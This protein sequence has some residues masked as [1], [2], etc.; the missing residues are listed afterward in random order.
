MEKPESAVFKQP[1]GQD[2]ECEEQDEDEQVCAVLSVTL[3]S[4]FLC[5]DVLHSTVLLWWCCSAYTDA[6]RQAHQRQQPQRPRCPPGTAD[7]HFM[8]H[9]GRLAS[10]EIRRL[11]K[12]R[13]T[14]CKYYP[15]AGQYRSAKRNTEIDSGPEVKLNFLERIQWF[16]SI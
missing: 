16:T 3:L 2:G 11:L 10:K 8:G 13:Q 6:H 14:S 12:P 7:S 1:Y 15:Q 5:N 4:L 9:F